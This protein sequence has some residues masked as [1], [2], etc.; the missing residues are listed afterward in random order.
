[1]WAVLGIN[2]TTG[3]LLLVAYPTKELT[4]LDFYVKLTFITLGVITMQKVN[5]QVFGDASLS[6]AAMVAKGKML[7]G[8]SLFFWIGA[9]TLGRL[10]PETAIY[11][12]FGRRVGG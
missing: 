6:E 5:K 10:L 12:T 3:L 7:A 9:V 4:N 2:A 1:M 11:D 8:W